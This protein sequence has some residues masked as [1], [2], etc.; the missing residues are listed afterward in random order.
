MRDYVLYKFIYINIPN[1]IVLFYI[2]D[3]F[4]FIYLYKKNL[5]K[6]NKL[7]NIYIA[8]RILNKTI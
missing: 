8:K 6:I 4:L 5:I 1:K 2:K 7:I 3:Y